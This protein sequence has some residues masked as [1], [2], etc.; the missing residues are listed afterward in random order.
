MMDDIM[1]KMIGYMMDGII[2]R[3]A[4]YWTVVL[5]K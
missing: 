5:I 2:K 4:V 1:H 3:L